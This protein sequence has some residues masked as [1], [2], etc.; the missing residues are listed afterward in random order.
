MGLPLWP[1]GSESA[2]Q[3]RGHGSDPWSGK[4]PHA[5][6][7]LARAPQLLTQDPRACELQ[8]LKPVHL[9]PM[10]HNKRQ[11]PT[12][13]SQRQDKHDKEDL[14][15]TKTNKQKLKKKNKGSDKLKTRLQHTT[16]TFI[17]VRRI[18]G[19]PNKEYKWIHQV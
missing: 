8:L 12:Q 3:C 17:F 19:A 5:A 7:Q 2:C 11:V 13:D 6:E 4:I 14:A 1:R 15:Q 10:L 16:K 18:Y 9:E